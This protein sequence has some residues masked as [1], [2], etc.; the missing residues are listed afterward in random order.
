MILRT[1]LDQYKTSKQGCEVDYLSP[2][3]FNRIGQTPLH[4]L[5]ARTFSP[6]NEDLMKLLLKNSACPQLCDVNGRDVADILAPNDQRLGLISRYSSKNPPGSLH[7]TTH[8]SSL[9]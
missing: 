8:H 2:N 4:L 6:F 5:A 7:Y 3:M 9:L 1:L